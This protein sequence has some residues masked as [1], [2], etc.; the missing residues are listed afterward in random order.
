MPLVL[1]WTS[2]HNSTL[3][4]I[5]IITLIKIILI[6]IILFIRLLPTGGTRANRSEVFV[7]RCRRDGWT[8]VVGYEFLTRGVTA[9]RPVTAHHSP[10][11][12]ACRTPEL[13]AG[14]EVFM[15]T[16]SQRTRRRRRRGVDI[17]Q[18]ECQAP[19]CDIW[20]TAAKTKRNFNNFRVYM[21]LYNIYYTAYA[22]YNMYTYYIISS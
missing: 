3:L 19:V 5:I 1:V 17:L 18:P 7:A 2:R 8:T 16:E 13:F 12:A 10:P 22:L 15:G 4:I 14:L 21:A 20:V 6:L 9:A 11:T